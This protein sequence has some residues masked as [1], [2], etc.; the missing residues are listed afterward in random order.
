MVRIARQIMAGGVVLLLLFIFVGGRA[1]ADTTDST[2]Y[3]GGSYGGCN[4]GSCTITLTSGSSISL[5]ILPTQTGKCTVKSDTASVLTDNPN[6]YDLTMTTSTTDTAMIG[7]SASINTSSGTAAA[8]TTLAMN[9]WGYRV[10]GLSGFGSGP[11]GAQDSGNVPSV[12]F[13]GVAP[14]DQVGVSL[15]SSTGAADPA[16]DTVVWY[17]ACVDASTPAGTYT[18]TVLYTAVTN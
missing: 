15:A 8:P 17:G 7:S 2:V 3:G 4:Y 13:A 11:T 10:D 16:E 12:T 14:S 5:D 6:G 9:T 18:T 1:Y